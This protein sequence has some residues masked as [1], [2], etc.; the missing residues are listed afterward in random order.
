MLQLSYSVDCLMLLVLFRFVVNRHSVKK[1]ILRKMEFSL[2]LSLLFSQFWKLDIKQ[3]STRDHCKHF[4][5]HKNL[6]CL[7]LYYSGTPLY[8]HLVKPLC[9]D[10]NKTQSV[11]QYGHPI[12]SARLCSPLVTRLMQFH[13][14]SVCPLAES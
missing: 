11:I 12:N 14:S 13:Y 10:L 1:G 2:L 4:Y 5:L 6:H 8:S 7:T 3:V 9:S